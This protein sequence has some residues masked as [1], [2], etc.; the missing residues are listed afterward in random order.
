MYCLMLSLGIRCVRQSELLGA[1]FLFPTRVS[2]CSAFVT[3]S[4]T[5]LDPRNSRERVFCAN[6]QDIKV[7]TNFP[8]HKFTAKVQLKFLYKNRDYSI[9]DG[10]RV[11]RRLPNLVFLRRYLAKHASS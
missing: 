8:N 7:P 1:S 6:F 10:K 2:C 11:I 4:N 9:F 5:V 3:V